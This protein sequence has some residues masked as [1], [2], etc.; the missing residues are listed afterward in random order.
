MFYYICV[1]VLNVQ[2]PYVHM[3]VREQLSGADSTT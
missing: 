3:E 1:T 2:V